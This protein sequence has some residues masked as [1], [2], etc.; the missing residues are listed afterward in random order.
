M[1]KCGRLVNREAD[2]AGLLVI[3]LAGVDGKRIELIR[4][5]SSPVLTKEKG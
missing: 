5:G 2:R 3:R 1:L 4:H